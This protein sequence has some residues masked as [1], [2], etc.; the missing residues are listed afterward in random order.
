MT[1]F[2]G[3]TPRLIAVTSL[4]VFLCAGITGVWAT[5]RHYQHVLCDREILIEAAIARHLPGVEDAIRV[6]AARKVAAF[7]R[8]HDRIL[9]QFPDIAHFS[10]VFDG[11]ESSVLFE[12]GLPIAFDLE[13]AKA[14]M[15]KNPAACLPAHSGITPLLMRVIP[16]G[17]LSDGKPAAWLRIGLTSQS[18]GAFLLG[19][20]RNDIIFIFGI[21]FLSVFAGT[22][23]MAVMTRSL[24]SVA[25][26]AVAIER[27]EIQN[28]I[29][30]T[31]HDEASTIAEA[32]NMVL[33][34]LRQSYV[35]TLGALAALL[36]TKDRMTETH[37]LR[38]VRY[39][40]ELGR[41]A[42][43]SKQEMTEL[44]YGALLHDIGKIGIADII[45]KKTGP[46]TE[47]EWQVMRQH[48]TIGYNV[49]KNLEFLQN[50][51]PVVLHHQERYDGRGYPNGLKGE[52]IPLLARIF[53]IAD[54]FDAMTSDR[55]YRHAMN[56]DVAV[57]EI[58]R[59]AGAQFDPRLV[60]IFSK[61]W[62]EGR[63]QAAAVSGR[64]N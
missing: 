60:E 43:L 7:Q 40:L 63:L 42:G 34:R 48:P 10:V 3:V 46:L 5:Y 6:P 8:L 36:E 13:S 50:S 23:L 18:F 44:E 39:A 31:G 58:R 59:N 9:A 54:S 26:Y 29:E 33:H 20:L 55:P 4:I 16:I 49:L 17:D 61:L 32:F 25:S 64:L 15:Q 21:L 53:T 47:E 62:S 22:V 37:S 30:I 35:S 24:R 38:G 12:K 28:E 1:F 56:E 41:G 19:S 2:R 14:C 27:G 11:P 57:Q 51:L 45:L 52:Q